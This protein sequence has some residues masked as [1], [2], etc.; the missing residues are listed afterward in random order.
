MAWTAAIPLVGKLIDRIFPDKEAQ[1]KAKLE[2]LALEQSGE[3]QKIVAASEVV[4]A[5]AQSQHWIT[6]T[7]RP[8]MMLSFV[9]IIVNNYIVYPYLSLFWAEAPILDLPLQ[10]WDL[11]KIGVGGY[12]VGRSGEKIMEKYKGK[13]DA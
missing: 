7:W 2:L 5:E 11:L 10:M 3:L 4:K 6:A 13:S 8:I 12:I 9:A 1:D